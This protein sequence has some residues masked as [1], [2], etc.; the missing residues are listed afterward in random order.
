M[1]CVV[2]RLPSAGTLL[3]DAVRAHPYARVTSVPT[4]WNFG[5]PQG[6]SMEL[7]ALVEGLSD[8]E[9]AAL[10]L[11]WNRRYG[12][13]AEVLGESFALRLPVRLDAVSAPGMR[14]LLNLDPELPLLGS[15]AEED[16]VEQ[17]FACRDAGEAESVAARLRQVLRAVSGV[18]IAIRV[19]R[20]QDLACWE[21]LHFA[22]GTTPPLAAEA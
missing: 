14:Q 18:E 21:V 20:Q 15:V 2:V 17:W 8:P 7:L 1:P 3:G 4:A 12:R 16:W 19:P 6:S 5:D 9:L 22:S 13:P 11:A 10:L